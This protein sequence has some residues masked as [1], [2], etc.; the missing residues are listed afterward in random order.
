LKIIVINSNNKSK[1][2]KNKNKAKVDGNEFLLQ[3]KRMVKRET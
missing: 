1:S 3:T 2:Y